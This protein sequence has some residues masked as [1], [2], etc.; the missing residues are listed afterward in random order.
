VLINNKTFLRI[1]LSYLLILIVPMS[2]LGVINYCQTFRIIETK[3]END[4]LITLEQSASMVDSYIEKLYRLSSE[5]TL[6]QQVNSFLN[7]SIDNNQDLNLLARDIMADLRN[8]T[9]LND[10]IEEMYIY[11]EVNNTFISPTGLYTPDIFFNSLYSNTDKSHSDK[12]LDSIRQ[13]SYRTFTP[14]TIKPHFYGETDKILFKDSLPSKKE[15]LGCIL[16]FMDKRIFMDAFSEVLKEYGGSYYVLDSQYRII[17]SDGS[18]KYDDLLEEGKH[19]DANAV[20][21]EQTTGERVLMIQTSS[22]NSKW[23][24]VA[25]IPYYAFMKEIN[26][27][28]VSTVITISI[29]IVLAFIMSLLAANRNYKPIRDIVNFIQRTYKYSDSEDDYKLISNILEFSYKELN[30]NKEILESHIPMIR[31]DYLTKLLKES[32]QMEIGKNEFLNS[33]LDI[34]LD[35]ESSVVAMFNI[36]GMSSGEGGCTETEIY[37]IALCTAIEEMVV[38]DC[39]VYTV[40]LENDNVAG[41]FGMNESEAKKAEKDVISIVSGLKEQLEEKFDITLYA[42]I[43]HAY[44]GY[45]DISRSYEEADESLGYALLMNRDVVCYKDIIKNNNHFAFPIQKELQ[46]INCIKSGKVTGAQKI[47]DDLYVENCLNKELTYEMMKYFIFDLYCCII[48]VTREL[49]IEDANPIIGNLKELDS[50]SGG[51]KDISYYLSDIRKKVAYVCESMQEQRKNTYIKLKNDIT[52][53]IDK[54]YLDSQLSLE[55]VANEF[56]ITPQ[57]LSRFFKEH[58]NVGYVDYVNEKRINKAKEYLLKDEKIKDVSVKSGFN[59]VGTFINAF[60][61]YTGYKPGEYKENMGKI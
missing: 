7:A 15:N 10:F 59:N 31:H 19:L 23:K 35:F 36:K 17:I 12:L 50:Q 2:I 13:A 45:K 53:Y 37:K 46:L 54:N 33:L 27:L 52:R 42:G 57:Y 60:K 20:T 41:I 39:K 44:K 14:V 24:Y 28:K 56:N 4:S 49:N 38:K 30:L 21:R 6:N 40:R 29:C 9:V 32:G 18:R 34:S 26:S 47:I 25:V 3:I 58:F 48:K 11:S 51:Q 43:G 55:K 61:K 1:F 8:Y 5:L 22:S 16:V